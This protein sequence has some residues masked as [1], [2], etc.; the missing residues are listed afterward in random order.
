MK[1]V[2]AHVDYLGGHPSRSEPKS[3][4]ERRGHLIADDFGIHLRSLKGAM[5]GFQEFFVIPWSEVVEV[6]VE[7]SDDT[8]CLSVGANSYTCGFEIHRPGWAMC[9]GCSPAGWNG[10]R[11]TTMMR[12]LTYLHHKAGPIAAVPPA[13][14]TKCHLALGLRRLGRGQGERY[15]SKQV[16][17]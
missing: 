6:V 8:T 7:G 16:R 2:F 4:A 5:P 11:G 10:S 1:V 9:E 13:N 14:A 15:V 17:E 12:S 3:T